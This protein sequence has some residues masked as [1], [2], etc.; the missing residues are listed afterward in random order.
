MKKIFA[1]AWKD[2]IIRFASSSELLFFIILPVVFTFLLAGGSPSGNEDPRIRLLVV[3]EAQ[4][5]ISKEIIG[6]LENSTAVYPEVTTREEA[7]D[8]FDNRRASAVFIIP[9]G[10]S[11]ESL[12]AGSAEVEL[13]QQPNNL[14]ATVAERATEFCAA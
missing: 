7:Q 13:L 14:N 8:Q 3:D 4:T 1:I 10:M 5:T 2:A 6:E 12:Q 11:M 9:A